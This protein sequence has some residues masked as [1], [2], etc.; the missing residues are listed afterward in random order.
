MGFGED[1]LFED[2]SL[3]ADWDIAVRMMEEF[4][5]EDRK[6]KRAGAIKLK[7]SNDGSIGK[8]GIG[9]SFSNDSGANRRTQLAELTLEELDNEDNGSEISEDYSAA[10]SQESLGY[11]KAHGI[12]RE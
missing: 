2:S 5:R 12:Y 6:L 3:A 4:S 11:E 7:R 8:D 1:L 10:E 9:R